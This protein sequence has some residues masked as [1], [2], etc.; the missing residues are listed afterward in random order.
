MATNIL[1]SIS[2]KWSREQI[3]KTTFLKEF[4]NEIWLKAGK[5]E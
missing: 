5:Y 3:L 2:Q 4:F 1:I